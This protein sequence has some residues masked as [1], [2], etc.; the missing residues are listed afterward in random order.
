MF[1]GTWNVNGQ[2]ATESIIPW[3]Q[4]DADP[5]DVYAF[6]YVIILPCCCEI[7]NV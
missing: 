5:P 3:I 4:Q 6:G 2:A 1:V 7:E